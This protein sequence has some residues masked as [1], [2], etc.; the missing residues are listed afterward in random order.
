MQEFAATCEAV[1]AT[2]KKTAKVRVVVEYFRSRPDEAAQALS[3]PD[4][5]QHDFSRRA[6]LPYP[7]SKPERAT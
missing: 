5:E 6:E 2:T 4:F 1:A 3:W 7:I